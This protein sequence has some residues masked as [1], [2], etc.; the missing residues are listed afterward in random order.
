MSS[1]FKRENERTYHGNESAPLVDNT[2]KME[3]LS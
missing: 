1:A 2:Y 3:I